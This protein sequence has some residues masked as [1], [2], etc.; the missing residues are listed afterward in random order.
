MPSVSNAPGVAMALSR[1]NK[2]GSIARLRCIPRTI[3]K[4]GRSFTIV[5]VMRFGGPGV[6]IDLLPIGYKIRIRFEFCRK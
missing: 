3:T 4:S 6:A 5:P 1:R 2:Y